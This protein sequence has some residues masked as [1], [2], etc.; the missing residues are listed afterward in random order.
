LASSK[1]P[2]T[3]REEV[4]DRT[5]KHGAAATE[6]GKIQMDAKR[7]I[8][9]WD[10]PADDVVR[11]GDVYVL[12]S[13]IDIN[14]NP[15]G[16]ELGVGK[17][18]DMSAAWDAIGIIQDIIRDMGKVM[19]PSVANQIVRSLEVTIRRIAEN[20]EDIFDGEGENWAVPLGWRRDGKPY[21]VRFTPQ[22]NDPTGQI[23]D[24]EL[25]RVAHGRC[26]AMVGYTVVNAMKMDA[27]YRSSELAEMTGLS[28]PR[29]RRALRQA[30]RAGLVSV[31]R[32]GEGDNNTPLLYQATANRY[33]RIAK[34][35]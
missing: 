25:R 3:S 34:A 9:E 14:G 17:V 26:Q 32:M 23:S 22:L 33:Q 6:K 35:S 24:D 20:D 1:L 4:A 7:K 10:I 28:V 21:A 15:I 11:G 31:K 2:S 19:A 13:E 30:E 8:V 18:V 12:V 27:T 16:D 29:V 5:V